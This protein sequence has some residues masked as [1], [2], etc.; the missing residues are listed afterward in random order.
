MCSPQVLDDGVDG[1]DRGRAR[2]AQQVLGVRGPR[3]LRCRAP[4]R[5]RGACGVQAARA[6]MLQAAAAEKLDH[7]THGTSEFTCI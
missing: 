6:A 3:A 2:A 7:G 1:S 5:A 4:V